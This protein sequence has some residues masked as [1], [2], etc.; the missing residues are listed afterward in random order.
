[1]LFHKTARALTLATHYDALRTPHS[2]LDQN[3]PSTLL[4][5]RLNEPSLAFRPVRLPFSILNSD[6]P[7]SVFHL[8]AFVVL[9]K[10]RTFRTIK[11]HLK[12]TSMKGTGMGCRK[13]DHRMHS[14]VINTF[15]S[16]HWLHFF[17]RGYPLLYLS[18]I[19]KISRMADIVFSIHLS[20]TIFLC[21][22]STSL[23]H[24][25]FIIINHELQFLPS[26]FF[27]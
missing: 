9:Q 10:V 2:H 25:N 21:I 7:F 23:L 4:S 3:Q 24:R 14:L 16:L 5:V 15:S 17:S 26:F 13:R 27:L 8:F 11:A 20:I 18:I 12:F 19:N 1:M 6:Q 22:Y